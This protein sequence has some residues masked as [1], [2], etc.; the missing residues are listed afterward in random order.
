MSNERSLEVEV[1]GFWFRCSNFMPDPHQQFTTTV[2]IVPIKIQENGGE[3]KIAWR[4]N[5][6]KNCHDPDCCYAFAKQQQGGES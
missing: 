6:G 4:C 5:R 3:L 2:A 1:K